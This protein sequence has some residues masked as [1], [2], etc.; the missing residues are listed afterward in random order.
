MVS[1][2]FLQLFGIR[3]YEKHVQNKLNLQIDKQE[4]TGFYQ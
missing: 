1:I 4:E 3:A 2:C